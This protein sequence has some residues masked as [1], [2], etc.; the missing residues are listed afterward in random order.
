ME[1]NGLFQVITYD[2]K[3]LANQPTISTIEEGIK[4][5]FTDLLVKNGCDIN[6]ADEIFV[7][8]SG[9][10]CLFELF[11]VL[12]KI[13][14]SL[15]EFSKN[16]F[17][18]KRLVKSMVQYEEISPAYRR[19]VLSAGTVIGA[20]S[21]C[22]KHIYCS[23]SDLN[24]TLPGKICVFDF[25]ALKKLRKEIK[26]KIL[27]SYPEIDFFKIRGIQNL[28]IPN[29][30]SLTKRA[31][32][33]CGNYINNIIAP[34]TLLI[35]LL[36][37][38]SE[39]LMIK[40]H[41]HGSFP[42]ETYFPCAVLLDKTFP[43]EF[44]QLISGCKIRKLIS[45]ETS[46]VDKI[47][48]LVESN[49]VASRYWMLNIVEILPLYIAM[50]LKAK[51]AKYRTLYFFTDIHGSKDVFQI[52]SMHMENEKLLIE[53]QFHKISIS[54]LAVTTNYKKA[55]QFSSCIHKYII[56]RKKIIDMPV[57]SD[58]SSVLYVAGNISCT[59]CKEAELSFKLIH[60][61]IEVFL[62]YEGEC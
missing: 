47:S 6:A 29:S 38:S 58:G 5:Y 43:I 37:I 8:N 31:T 10:Y 59:E 48:H 53:N 44:L 39:Q 18:S 50:L 57:F 46:A 21:F 34:Y 1:Q 41:P 9:A 26:D 17:A 30:E 23:G 2:Y 60:S 7:S 32:A 22:K 24:T 36:S 33:I 11:L 27:A 55:I 14:Y 45:I 49:I 42:F 40:P 25:L 61:G 16:E 62:E 15:V 3:Y 19:L 4:T 28:L 56:V 12:W 51:L 13:P 35:D 52:L 20:N 54:E